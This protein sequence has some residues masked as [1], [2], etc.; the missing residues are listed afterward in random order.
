MSKSVRHY[1][2]KEDTINGVEV[3]YA[4]QKTNGISYFRALFDISTLPEEYYKYI[5]ILNSVFTLKCLIIGFNKY[6]RW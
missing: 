4:P 2:L 6:G 3:F 5:P 1:D